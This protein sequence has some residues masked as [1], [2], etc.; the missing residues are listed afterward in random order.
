MGDNKLKPA[1][2]AARRFSV[3]TLW[4]IASQQDDVED[5]LTKGLSLSLSFPFIFLSSGQQLFL[6]FY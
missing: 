2:D 5:D 4:S 3:N 1:D 6:F